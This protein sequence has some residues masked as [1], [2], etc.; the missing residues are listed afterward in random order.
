MSRSILYL[1]EQRYPLTDEMKFKTYFKYKDE[2]GTVFT[3]EADEK[4]TIKVENAFINSKYTKIVLQITVTSFATLR[5]EYGDANGRFGW[6]LGDIYTY[7][8]K[9]LLRYLGYPIIILDVLN[10]DEPLVYHRPKLTF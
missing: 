7:K 6:N 9:E 4:A 5:E 10:Q 8:F 2:Q 1:F 3:Q